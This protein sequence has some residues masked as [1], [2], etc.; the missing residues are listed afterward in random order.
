[1]DTQAASAYFVLLGSLL[2][3]E[4]S[5]QNI[6]MLKE[7]GLFDELPFAGDNEF[8]IKGQNQMNVW[9]KSAS[10][11]E[12]V[13]A[14]RT[15]WLVLLMGVGKVLAPPWASVYLDK[16]KLLFSEQTLHVRRFYEHYGFI[17]KQKYREPDDHLGL[18]LEF[19]AR[20][21]E[22]EEHEVADTF[23]RDYIQPWIG[24]W[25]KDVSLNAKTG[26]YRALGNLAVGGIDSLMKATWS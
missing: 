21:L 6:G 2:Y 4:P 9:L 20:L 15:D 23:I 7:Q 1:M 18:E 26:Y 11:E 13:S 22:R 19:I 14:A 25:N 8:A 12:L 10:V 17:I 3:N 16:D 24:V 5:V